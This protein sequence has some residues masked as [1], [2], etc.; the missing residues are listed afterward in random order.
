VIA[1]EIDALAA[2]ADAIL[3]P[4]TVVGGRVPPPEPSTALVVAGPPA[5]PAPPPPP[6]AAKAALALSELLTQRLIALDGVEVDG[7]RELRAARKAEIN[8]VNGLCDALDK[9][10]KGGP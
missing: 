2:Q 6:D 9:W 5:L 1:G 8:R 7:D 4:G 10:R 3:P